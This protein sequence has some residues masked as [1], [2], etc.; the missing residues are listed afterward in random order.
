[1]VLTCN[2]CIETAMLCCRWPLLGPATSSCLCETLRAMQTQ[3]EIQRVLKE[4][5]ENHDVQRALQVYSVPPGSVQWLIF[6]QVCLLDCSDAAGTHRHNHNQHESRHSPY[7]FW[8]TV[9]W[10]DQPPRWCATRV[11]NILS[12]HA[13]SSTQQNCVLQFSNAYKH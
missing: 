8:S 6:L 4:Q 5:L 10:T 11:L 7:G 3:E 9:P 13:I 1:M 12:L 2:S